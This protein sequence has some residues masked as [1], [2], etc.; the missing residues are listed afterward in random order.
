MLLAITGC[1]LR[2]YAAEDFCSMSDNNGKTTPF[3]K[4]FKDADL[5]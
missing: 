5:Q 1:Y 4:D 2:V 3:C